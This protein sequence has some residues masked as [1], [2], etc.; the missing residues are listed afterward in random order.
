MTR[1]LSSASKQDGADS[2]F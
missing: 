2:V 1:Q